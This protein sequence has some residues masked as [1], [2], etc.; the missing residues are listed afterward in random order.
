MKH[1]D[2]QWDKLDE[3]I[4]KSKSTVED[5]KRLNEIEEEKKKLHDDESKLVNEENEIRKKYKQEYTKKLNDRLDDFGILTV[6]SG[7]DHDEGRII[8]VTE[9]KMKVRYWYNY[10]S[11]SMDFII[12][13]KELQEKGYVVE[14]TP[15]SNGKIFIVDNIKNPMDVFEII[16][17][18]LKLEV[19]EQKRKLQWGEEEVEKG[20]DRIKKA[21][22]ELEK[23]KKV[24]DGMITRIFND[25]S[26]GV[27][28]LKIEDILKTL[29]REVCMYEDNKG[30]N[31]GRK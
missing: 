9:D 15:H 1:F 11:S 8:S 31:N 20:K 12:S 22:E 2:V 21:K 19:G 10:G 23:Y 25:I 6:V 24:S 4:E 16:K 26:F 30:D 3:F 5:F 27:T 17:Y 29:P 14:K 7:S 18:R 28:D 13:T